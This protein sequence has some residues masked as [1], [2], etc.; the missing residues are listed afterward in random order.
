[1]DRNDDA[2]SKD[3]DDAIG[4]TGRQE[5]VAGK[6]DQVAGK[7]KEGLGDLTGN[8]NLQAEGEADQAKG[9][10]KEGIGNVKE[11]AENLLGNKND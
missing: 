11:A 4:R 1:M 3:V 6:G 10:V 8:R 7:V 5:K 9:K 2:A